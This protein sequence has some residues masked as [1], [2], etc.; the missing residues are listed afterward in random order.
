MDVSDGGC[1]DCGGWLNDISRGAHP[2]VW[3]SGGADGPAVIEGR[4][5]VSSAKG[6]AGVPVERAGG[7][8]GIS[9]NGGSDDNGSSD[10]LSSSSSSAVENGADSVNGTEVG[11]W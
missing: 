1:R 10:K 11:I 9:D 5:W 3:S 7:E 4:G 8:G 2:I 6:P